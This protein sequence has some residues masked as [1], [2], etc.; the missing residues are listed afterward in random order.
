MGDRIL[1]VDIVSRDHK[2]AIEHDGS[3]WHREKQATDQEKSRT[4][5]EAGWR[6]IR[7]R[8]APS[9]PLGPKDVVAV[10]GEVKET[11]TDLI[12]R[13]LTLSGQTMAASG[14]DGKERQ[15]RNEVAAE[16]YIARLRVA[17]MPLWQGKRKAIR[18]DRL[19]GGRGLQSRTRADRPPTGT[20]CLKPSNQQP[21]AS[22]SRTDVC[23]AVF[24]RSA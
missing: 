19:R 21:K 18:E 23:W 11:A 17:S 6:V 1:K 8:E 12:S 22:P 4:L 9:V 3:F 13:V 7:I 10:P 24:P 5:A 15:L 20:I 14:S 16:K 2:S